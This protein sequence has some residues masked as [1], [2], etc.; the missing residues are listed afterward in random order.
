MTDPNAWML[1]EETKTDRLRTMLA[2][3][4]ADLQ[5]RDAALLKLQGELMA[6]RL[7]VAAAREETMQFQGMLRRAEEAAARLEATGHRNAELTE[8]HAVIATLR[9]ETSALRVGMDLMHASA[10]WRISAPV[11]VVGRLM[12]RARTVA[13]GFIRTIRHARPHQSAP[14]VEPRAISTSPGDPNE[15]AIFRAKPLV[16]HPSGAA[17][18]VVT[19]DALYHLSR[20]L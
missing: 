10:S 7:E 3:A 14:S 6:S 13:S 9:A 12:R 8:L 15:G 11:R 1:E 16:E 20:S 4:R 5:R 19:L 18:S 17:E 2:E